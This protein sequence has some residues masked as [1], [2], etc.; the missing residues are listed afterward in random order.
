MNVVQTFPSPSFVAALLACLVG[1]ADVDVVDAPPAVQESE[2]APPAAAPALRIGVM[3]ELGLPRT[4]LGRKIA[5]FVALIE[6]SEQPRTLSPEIRAVAKEAGKEL[7]TAYR[8]LDVHRHFDRWRIVRGIGM[9]RSDAMAT[10]LLEIALR[11]PA[12]RLRQ[13]CGVG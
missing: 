11:P 4:E 5:D 3:E 12:P 2:S 9:L 7:M 10:D 1:C 6:E 8:R 13:E